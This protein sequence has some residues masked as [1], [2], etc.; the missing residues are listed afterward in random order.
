MKV[1][2]RAV[3]SSDTITEKKDRDNHSGSG[4]FC[5]VIV[6]VRTSPDERATEL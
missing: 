2:N 6:H 4:G 5:I 3:V 1:T